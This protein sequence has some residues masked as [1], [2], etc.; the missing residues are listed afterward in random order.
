MTA[1]RRMMKN[2]LTALRERNRE[3]SL[4]LT[5]VWHFNA[6]RSVFSE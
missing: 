6:S 1:N 5:T 4:V 3:D 2:F